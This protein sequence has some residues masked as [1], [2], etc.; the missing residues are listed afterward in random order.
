MAKDND[1]RLMRDLQGLFRKKDG[2]KTFLEEM[3]KAVMES[4]VEQHI[5][6][7]PYERSEK[8]TG[9]RAGTTSSCTVASNARPV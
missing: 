1:T 3:L 7:T 8:R 5:G 6:A 2:V 9:Y 4:E